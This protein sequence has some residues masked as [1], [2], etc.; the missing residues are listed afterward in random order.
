MRSVH[1]GSSR[2][3]AHTKPPQSRSAG[4]PGPG[5]LVVSSA[6]RSGPQERS[7]QLHC[8]V[9]SYE[10]SAGPTWRTLAASR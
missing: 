1:K 5:E 3:K 10:D 8:S 4:P 7:P 2:R 9:C 6:G